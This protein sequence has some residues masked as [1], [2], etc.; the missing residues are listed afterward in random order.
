MN[1]TIQDHRDLASHYVAK[2]RK[3]ASPLMR[4][5]YLSDARKHHTLANNMAYFAKR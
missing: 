5:F 2:A 4:Q 1:Y 3:E